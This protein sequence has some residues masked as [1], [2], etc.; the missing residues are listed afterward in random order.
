MG[1]I[2]QVDSDS[3]DYE[4]AFAE[5][6]AE[7]ELPRYRVPQGKSDP[8]TVRELIRDELYLDGNAAQNVATFC[9]TY[10]D[11]DVRYLMDISVNKN[12]I[13]KDEYPQSADIENRC[14]CMLA[15]LWNAPHAARAMGCSTEGS[16]EACMLGGLALKRC[17]QAARQASRK[18]AVRPNLV[19]GPVQICWHKFARY[20]DVE[21]REVPLA[22]NALGMQPEQLADRCD[23]NTIGVITT[24]GVTF[25]GIY[26]PVRELAAALDDIQARTGLDIPIHVDAASG[27]FVAPFLQPGLEWDFRIPRVRSINSSGHKFGLAPLG[28]GWVVW[29]DAADLPED[30]VFRVDYL[31]GD[32]PTFALN[33]S[34]PAGQVIA[35]YYLLLRHGHVG[36]REIHQA[37]AGHARY[38]AERLPR[39]GPFQLL[40]DGQGALPAVCYTLA[41]KSAPFT[42]YDLS[43]RL[44]T[45]GW[46]VP[47]Y[48][49]PAGRQ[50]TTVQRILIRHGFSRDM[51]R[52][53]VRDIERSVAALSSGSRAPHAAFHHT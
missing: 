38:I 35:Q 7:R 33:F 26:E 50:D 31:G 22:G 39:I 6:I 8:R 51:A 45:R 17:W 21:L 3:R 23:E 47:S 41:D 53:L 34:R 20:F 9:T 27:G 19:C 13:D 1:T 29:R 48:P 12:L 37:C 44:R 28:V 15:A 16:S 49:L 40:Y 10:D 24:L 32:L 18:P 11:D 5:P 42:L 46:Q 14:V 2:Y 25:T 36:Y 4:D 52:F 43:D 30:L